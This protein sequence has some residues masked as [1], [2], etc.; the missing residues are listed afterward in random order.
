MSERDICKIAVISITAE[1]VSVMFTG[2]K[3]QVVL[4]VAPNAKII[5]K[6]VKA[7]NATD[8]HSCLYKSVEV[9]YIWQSSRRG[10]HANIVNVRRP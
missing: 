1:Q 7:A 6:M 9:E 10:K 2:A 8:I 5:R 3:I 4:S